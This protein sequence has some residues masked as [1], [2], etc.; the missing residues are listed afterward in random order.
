VAADKA[1]YTALLQAL[2]TQGLL[3]LLEPE[4]TLRVRS[5]DADLVRG[6]LTPAAAAFKDKVKKDVK[7][8]VDTASFLDDSCGGGVE[9]TAKAGK[10][11]IVN[12]LENRLHL[13]TQQMLPVA[14]NVLFG[15]TGS[16]AF[17]D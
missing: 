13:T 16:R 17:F 2:L 11:R 8:T 7:L 3:T 5:R 14:R 9:L 1:K 15:A 6:L 12:T 4:V 10:I